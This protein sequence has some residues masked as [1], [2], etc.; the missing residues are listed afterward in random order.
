MDTARDHGASGGLSKMQ[1]PVLGQAPA[2]GISG[3]EETRLIYNPM[4]WYKLNFPISEASI[5]VV[6]TAADLA[7]KQ[8]EKKGNLGGFALFS[9]WD[10]AKTLEATSHLVYFSPVAG[11]LC[12][13]LFRLQACSRPSS[14]EIE[15]LA[16]ICGD[17]DSFNLLK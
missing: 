7:R 14:R 10:W 9:C 5:K 6:Y 4:S 17:D 2:S 8:H 13:D 11:D 15:F 16:L 1:E 3:K 12:Q